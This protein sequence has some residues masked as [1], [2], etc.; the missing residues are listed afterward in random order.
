MSVSPTSFLSQ[1]I[2][3]EESAISLGLKDTKP[4]FKGDELLTVNINASCNTGKVAHVALEAMAYVTPTE[5][6]KTIVCSKVNIDT[7]LKHASFE[8]GGELR[9]GCSSE[10]VNQYFSHLGG[11]NDSTSKVI[12][13]LVHKNVLPK[14]ASFITF[15]ITILDESPCRFRREVRSLVKLK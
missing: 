15:K 3:N 14:N 9:N 2:Y 7:D 4:V 10:E 11:Q 5:E 12:R 6:G 8:F 1:S 13:A